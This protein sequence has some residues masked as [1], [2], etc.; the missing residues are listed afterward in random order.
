MPI[1]RLTLCG[2][3]SALNASTSAKIGSPA[4]GS[5]CSN[6]VWLQQQRRRAPL[7]GACDS[8]P[9]EPLHPAPVRMRAC[10]QVGDRRRALAGQRQPPQRALGQLLVVDRSVAAFGW[11]RVT[12]GYVRA[13]GTEPGDAAALHQL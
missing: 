1:D 5:T 9:I 4:Y 2:R 3:G 13:F 8:A 12:E 10:Q 11:R 6:T 7:S